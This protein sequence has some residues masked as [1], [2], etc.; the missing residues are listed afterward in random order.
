MT[1]SSVTCPH[2]KTS[3]RIT[4]VQLKAAK[5]SVRC[6]SCLQVFNALE[7]LERL[8]AKQPVSMVTTASEEPLP[9]LETEHDVLVSSEN[10]E[11][12]KTTAS[13]TADIA[14]SKAKVAT[15]TPPLEYDGYHHETVSTLIYKSDDH[16]DDHDEEDDDEIPGLRKRSRQN[17]PLLK[18]TVFVLATALI[19]QY[20]WFNRNQLALN[21]TLR[22]AYTLICS[23]LQCELPPLVNIKAIRSLDLVVRTHPENSQALQ[24]DAVIINDAGHTQP[25]P[26]IQLTFTDINGRLIASRAFSPSEYL[27]G[28]LAGSNAMPADQPIRLGLEI[29]DPG[30]SA[31][32]YQLTFAKSS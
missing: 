19:A 20:G 27:G 1:P 18:L 5:G 2:C 12:L 15:S 25:Y 28:E 32:S 17:S 16:S 24:I 7:Q 21:T 4:N 22:P 11:A 29:M 31:V 23:A 3:F 9:A 13:P 10:T 8:P 26:S 14:S 30:P 6:G